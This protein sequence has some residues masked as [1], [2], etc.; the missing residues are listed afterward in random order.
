MVVFVYSLVPRPPRAMQ[1][2]RWY[3]LMCRHANIIIGRPGTHRYMTDVSTV[4]S[5]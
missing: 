5:L 1:K 2:L 4:Q 3:K